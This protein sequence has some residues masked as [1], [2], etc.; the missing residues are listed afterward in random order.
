MSINV[1]DF[2]SRLV[3]EGQFG[4]LATLGNA[5][6]QPTLDLLAAMN[7]RLAAIWSEADWKWARELLK[8]ALTPKV[9]QYEVTAV[10]G[11][12]IDR[13]QLLIPF[14][15]S[16]LFAP[17]NLVGKPLKGHTDY[18]FY[19]HVM[20]ESWNGNS[21]P[22]TPT[23]SYGAPRDYYVVEINPDGNWLIVVDP[24]PTL[25]AYMGGFAKAILSTYQLADVAANNPILYFPNGVVNDALF[26]GM[27]IDVFLLKGGD[28]GKA[29]TMEQ[30]FEAKIRRLAKQQIGV[31][32][33]NTPRQTR[34]PGVVGRLM[35]GGRRC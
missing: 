28:L 9:R 19:E 31:T 26:Q 13:I 5:G 30:A 4:N 33:D 15:S 35:R 34:M 3:R 7:N 22:G 27:M 11:N 14:D 21:V 16:G 2:L 18:D 8:F 20:Q 32:A 6:D 12:F 1:K 29:A 17:A 23:P 24:M 25:A 10:S